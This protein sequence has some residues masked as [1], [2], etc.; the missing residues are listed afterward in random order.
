MAN[1]AD[2]RSGEVPR[3]PDADRRPSAVPETRKRPMVPPVLTRNGS[4][5]EVTG[6]FVGTFS[7]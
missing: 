6:S 1:E 4:L 2:A 7:P 5:P 3:S